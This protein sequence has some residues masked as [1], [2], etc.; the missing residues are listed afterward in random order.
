[1]GWNNMDIAAVK[2]DGSEVIDLTESGYNDYE[3]K[4]VLDGKAVAYETAK[5]GMKAHGSWGNQDDIMIMAL[6]GDAW[7]QF[8]FTEEE[9]DI[10]DKEIQDKEENKDSKEPVTKKAP[11]TKKGKKGNKTVKEETKKPSL[12]FAN[13]RYRTKRLTGTSARIMDFYLSPKGDKLYYIAQG[14]DGE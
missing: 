6:D 4:W 3:P 2:A 7:D 1:M 5:Y 13:R 12:D 9:A 8:N 14:P 11:K 10:F